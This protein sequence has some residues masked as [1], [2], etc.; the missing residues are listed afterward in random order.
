MTMWMRQPEEDDVNVNDKWKI[1]CECGP[2][3][4]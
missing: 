1:L 2:Q 4:Q 3:R